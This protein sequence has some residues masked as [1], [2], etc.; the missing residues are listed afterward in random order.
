[1]L[2]Q[3]VASHFLICALTGKK[4]S[5]VTTARATADLAD[6]SKTLRFPAPE[7]SDTSQLLSALPEHVLREWAK[8]HSAGRLNKPRLRLADF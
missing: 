5:D 4:F 2:T 1:M 6:L 7:L 3:Q 8:L